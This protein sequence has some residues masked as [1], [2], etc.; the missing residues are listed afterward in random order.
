MEIGS[1]K[2]QWCRS[3]MHPKNR[4]FGWLGKGSRRCVEM[5]GEVSQLLGEGIRQRRCRCAPLL[6]P[7]EENQ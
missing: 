7:K 1:E 5:E 6:E 4:R 3:S 2:D